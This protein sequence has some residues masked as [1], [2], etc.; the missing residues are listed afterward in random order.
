MAYQLLKDV[1]YEPDASKY[2]GDCDKVTAEYED[3]LKPTDILRPPEFVGFK[4]DALIISAQTEIYRKGGHALA[5]KVWVDTNPPGQT[6]LKRFCKYKIEIYAHGSI[7]AWVTI[8]T[9]LAIILGLAFITWQITHTKWGA[10]IPIA[11]IVVGLA[12]LAS[13]F[14]GKGKKK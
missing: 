8:L 4:A 14:W 3:I 11:L 10:A 2:R 5:A 9:A 7:L 12:I 13:T 1:R 6:L